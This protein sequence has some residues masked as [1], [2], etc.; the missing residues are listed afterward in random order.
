[1]PNAARV[2]A[3]AFDLQPQVCFV[4]GTHFLCRPEV[5][6]LMPMV[7]SMM[8]SRLLALASV[9]AMV[10]LS[11]RTTMGDSDPRRN[12]K[13]G[14]DLPKDSLLVG[15]PLFFRVSL[16][17]GGAMPIH[18]AYA[19]GEALRTCTEI[20]IRIARDGKEVLLRRCNGGHLGDGGLVM[21]WGGL[22]TLDPGRCMYAQFTLCLVQGDDTVGT[23]WLT[24]GAYTVKAKVDL[25]GLPWT[26]ETQE[27]PLRILPIADGAKE[28]LALWTP[29]MAEILRYS[30]QP[31]PEDYRKAATLKAKF[32]Q[33]PHIMH[34]EFFL[35]HEEA[36]RNS[37]ACR[38][39]LSEYLRDYPA[40]PYVPDVLFYLGDWERTT[41]GRG[42]EAKACFRRI[43]KEFPDHWRAGMAADSL[44]QIEAGESMLPYIKWAAPK[45]V[46]TAAPV[47]SPPAQRAPAPD[48]EKTSPPAA[49]PSTPSAAP[50][51]GG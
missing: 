48:K 28:F 31:K 23:Q 16:T 6:I 12:L 27:L 10:L 22:E 1:M 46:P 34:L 42:G 14:L 9:L 43:L 24:P 18:T 11:A 33:S 26:L 15:E 29:D 35:V 39:R 44:A 2:A 37:P 50:P 32:P 21:P 17:N 38:T 49:A 51:S 45:P 3:A 25:Q 5:L 7:I 36:M 20:S 19:R 4:A 13:A 41:A 47:V 30:H 40:S 8:S